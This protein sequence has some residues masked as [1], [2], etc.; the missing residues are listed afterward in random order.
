M[1]ASQVAEMMRLVNG[2]QISQS[3]HVAAALGIADYLADGPRTIDDS[4]QSLA[5]TH[6]HCTG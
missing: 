2:Y 3:I 5:H 4:L 6:P 1:S